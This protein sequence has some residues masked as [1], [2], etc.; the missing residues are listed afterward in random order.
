MLTSFIVEKFASN[1]FESYTLFRSP[2]RKRK[3]RTASNTFG[4]IWPD[5]FGGIWHIGAY[6]NRI[7]P[8]VFDRPA[9]FP[10]TGTGAAR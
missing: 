9:A 7:G 6:L 4:I 5:P 1:N 2:L 3:L 10:E 8:G